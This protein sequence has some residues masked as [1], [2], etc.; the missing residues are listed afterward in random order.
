MND[1]DRSDLQDILD[2]FWR[3]IYTRWRNDEEML[4]H[5]RRQL[6]DMLIGV[7]NQL[8]RLRMSNALERIDVP[9]ATAAVSR[10]RQIT[11]NAYSR[12]GINLNEL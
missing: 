3:E 8:V 7:E 10:P 6:E 1:R 5:L 11:I 4:E 2:K 9:K 12:Y